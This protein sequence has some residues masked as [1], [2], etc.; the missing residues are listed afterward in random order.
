MTRNPSQPYSPST[1]LLGCHGGCSSLTH[2]WPGHVLVCALFVIMYL[3][4][5][6]Y[7]LHLSLCIC[8]LCICVIMYLCF[9]LVCPLLPW[10]LELLSPLTYHLRI[11]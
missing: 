4:L 3:C 9:R 5:G 8:V 6:C 1:P 2:T 11:Q 7:S 10:S